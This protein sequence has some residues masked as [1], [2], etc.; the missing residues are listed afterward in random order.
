MPAS[1]KDANRAPL[2]VVLTANAAAFWGLVTTQQVDPAA[3]VGSIQGNIQG[4]LPIGLALVLTGIINS[5]M[6]PMTKARLVFFEWEHPLPGAQA[7]TKFMHRDARIDTSML[8]QKYG[9]LPTE[10]GEQN[11]RWYRIYQTVRNQPSVV[12]ANKGYLFGRDYASLMALLILVFGALSLALI[13]SPLV[14]MSYTTALIFQFLLAANSARNH[15]VR[16][17]TNTLAIASQGDTRG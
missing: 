9:P 13:K 16:L 12:D 4:S 2:M 11:R 1:H 17:V 10:P 7:F 3:W 15:A 6:S 5:Q 14:Y 8:D